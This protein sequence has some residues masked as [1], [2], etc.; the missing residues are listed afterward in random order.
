MAE[1]F[2]YRGGGNAS[3]NMRA[4]RRRRTW[5]AQKGNDLFIWTPGSD[6]ASLGG[7]FNRTTVA[8]YYQEVDFDQSEQRILVDAAIDEL[9]DSHYEIWP[10]ETTETQ[11]YRT[12]WLEPSRTN[13]ATFSEDFTNAVWT[14]AGVTITPNESDAPDAVVT[15]MDKMVESI[16]FE[17][18]LIS[19]NYTIVAGDPVAASFFV[20]ESGRDLVR[21]SIVGNPTTA[22]FIQVD[23]N[24]GDGSF[25][26][27]VGGTGVALSVFVD[28]DINGSLRIGVAGAPGGLDVSVTVSIILLNASGLTPYTGDGVS[29]ANVWG[30]QF[31]TGT[32]VVFASSYQRATGAATVLR[33][34]DYL[35]FVWPEDSPPQGM[36]LIFRYTDR[37]LGVQSEFAA[38]YHLGAPATPGSTPFIQVSKLDVV[39]GLNFEHNVPGSSIVTPSTVDAVILN[40]QD[41]ILR[42]FPD[43]HLKAE[44]YTNGEGLEEEEDLVNTPGLGADW[45]GVPSDLTIAG[46]GSTQTGAIA[47]H[48]F[49]ISTFVERSWNPVQPPLLDDLGFR[50][51]T[52]ENPDLAF[53]ENNFD[54]VFASDVDADT[55][56]VTFNDDPT[57]EEELSVFGRAFF[58]TI[59]AA[60]LAE[61]FESEA[62]S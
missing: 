11:V 58:G 2:V 37:G 55:G 62:F 9:R 10:G 1:G 35:R 26:T 60:F 61:A 32:D 45:A 14:K 6:L 13:L 44:V 36:S 8:T 39:T 4:I 28:E 5:L 12:A 31:E 51:D 56:F 41:N 53:L 48:G 33:G 49:A 50:I 29:G 34:F 7:S 20:K 43:G 57:N 52:N 22:N 15:S 24:L 3:S 19:R 16:I 54:D 27:V 30:A 46:L 25:T 23:V 59:G 47:L 42:M 40:I 18:H 38:L 21:I 17:D